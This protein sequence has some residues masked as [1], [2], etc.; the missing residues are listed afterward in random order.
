MASF[1]DGVSSEPAFIA[2]I[3]YLNYDGDNSANRNIP[4]AGQTA[5]NVR[6]KSNAV[7]LT[8]FWAPQ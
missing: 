2:R 4:I 3:N 1:M 6:A 7:G 5:A 8:L